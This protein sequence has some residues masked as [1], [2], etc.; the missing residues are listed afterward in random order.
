MQVYTAKVLKVFQPL[1]KQHKFSEQSLHF[2]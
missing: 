2:K 1:Q